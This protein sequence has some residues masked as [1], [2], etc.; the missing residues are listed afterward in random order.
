M[1]QR[2][3]ISWHARWPERPNLRRLPSLL[4][5]G[6]RQ[7]SG[8]GERPQHRQERSERRGWSGSE[9]LASRVIARSRAPPTHRLL[10]HGPCIHRCL[11]LMEEI[12][13]GVLV[14]KHYRGGFHDGALQGRIAAV[15]A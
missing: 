12:A 2:K 10:A 6:C 7:P 5:E 15:A 9:P 4:L 3:E 11:M 13:K 8:H 14:Y 1:R